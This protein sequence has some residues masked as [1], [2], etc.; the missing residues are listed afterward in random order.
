MSV[1]YNRILALCEERNISGYRL[2][3]D[4]GVQPSVLTDLKM[5]RQSGLSAKNADKLASV[6]GVSVGYLLGTE[7]KKEAPALTEKDKRDVAKDVYLIMES[8]ESSG[9]LMFDGVPM[10]EESKAAMAAAMRIGLEE[11]RRR[12]KVTYTPKKFRKE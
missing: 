12:N 6:L 3:K 4:A 9:E 7:E 8:L 5:G 11:A 1:L 10:S 2:C